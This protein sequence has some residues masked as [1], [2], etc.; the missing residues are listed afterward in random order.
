MAFIS[1]PTGSRPSTSPWIWLYFAITVPLTALTFLV[2][3]YW[4][5]RRPLSAGRNTDGN[6][7]TTSGDDEEQGLI[8]APEIPA[9]RRLSH[10]GDL[11]AGSLDDSITLTDE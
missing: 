9:L 10:L 5:R 1:S 8:V 4:K 2:W 3:T 11:C 6:G 7:A